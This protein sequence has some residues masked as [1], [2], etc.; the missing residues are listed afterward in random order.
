MDAIS[1][2]VHAALTPSPQLYGVMS[3]RQQPTSQNWPVELACVGVT[4][5]P[6]A[7]AGAAVLAPWFSL[8]EG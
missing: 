3:E 6:P 4:Q 8:V 7:P 5:A 1:L 2:D